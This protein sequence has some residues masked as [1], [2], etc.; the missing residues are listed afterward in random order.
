MSQHDFLFKMAADECLSSLSE[1]NISPQSILILG[2]FP[3]MAELGKAYPASTIQYCPNFTSDIH[4]SQ[5]YDLIL[6]IGQLQW[7]NDPITYLNTFNSILNVNGMLYGIFPGEH[8]FKNLH[9]ALIQAELTLRNGANQRVIPMISASDTLSMLQ[10]SG[11]T[12]PLV[13]ITSLEL[14]HH[15][16]NE[17][18]DD[19]RSMGGSNPLDQRSK[20]F[21]PKALFS[22]ANT[23]LTKQQH[24]LKT[25]VDLITMSGYK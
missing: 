17:L 8:S 1:T 4:T 15:S 20:Y 16:I 9:E 2:Y 3:L 25:P 19:I 21:A 12:Q 10:I 24:P 22:L 5:V 23:L 13:H 18:M 11:F 14:H 6:S 7:I